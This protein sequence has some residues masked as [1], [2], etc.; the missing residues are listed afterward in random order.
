MIEK[1]FKRK[2]KKSKKN[3][4]II[5]IPHW[6]IILEPLIKLFICMCCFTKSCKSLRPRINQRYLIKGEEKLSKELEIV[7]L[8][9]KVRVSTDIINHLIRQN[10]Q[11][12]Y[13]EM[14]NMNKN[15]I[16]NDNT[17]S[18]PNDLSESD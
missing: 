9:K 8:I 13:K 2:D 12:V 17:S 1:Y 3:F 4:K 18:S 15:F 5:E 10:C 11:N 6:H 16:L 7:K 14:I